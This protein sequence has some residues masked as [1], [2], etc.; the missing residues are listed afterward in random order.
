MDGVTI[1]NEIEI[2]QVVND[3]FNYT[4]AFIALIVTIL[5]CA[6]VGFFIG[7][8]ECDEVL[9]TLTGVIIGLVLSLFVGA[10]FGTLFE[11]PP[12]TETTTQYEVILDDSVSMNEFY[13]HYNVV[14]QRGEIFVVGEKE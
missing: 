11:Y 2:V 3:T 9:G 6:V 8:M 7:R 12:V 13:E 1:L 4:A 10:L 14:E 5:T